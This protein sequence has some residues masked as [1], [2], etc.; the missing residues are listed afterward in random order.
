MSRKFRKSLLKVLAIGMGLFIILSTFLPKTNINSVEYATGFNNTITQEQVKDV[1]EEIYNRADIDIRK[2]LL[3]DRIES[4]NLLVHNVSSDVE[5]ILS[6]TY[7]DYTASHN[8]SPEDNW[9]D[10]LV[11]SKIEVAL[12]C[13]VITSIP[14][15]KVS[16]SVD[17]HGVVNVSYSKADIK[18]KSININKYNVITDKKILGHKYTNEEVLALIEIAQGNIR[19][20]INNDQSHINNASKTLENY[21]IQIGKE[22]QVYAINFNGEYTQQIKGF[23]YVDN[24]NVRF[25]HPNTSMKH[26]VKYIV[27]HSTAND[28]VGALA[29]DKYL[30]TEQNSNAAHYYVDDKYVVNTLDNNMYGYHTGND[31]NGE[32]VGIEVCEFTDMD[33]QLKTLENTKQLITALKQEFPNAEVVFHHDLSDVSKPCPSLVFVDKSFTMNE[34]MELIGVED[35]KI[36]N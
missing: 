20:R 32:S 11:D 12:N 36:I 7:C 1:E 3:Q 5:Y 30:N 4:A 23:E 16:L 22:F 31:Y 24:G 21:F 25:G 17:K 26:E 15:N 29:H 14:A 8:S 19:D 10:W 13:E 28:N 33:R 35:Y 18:V 9:N 2:Q 27:V 34:F 6:T